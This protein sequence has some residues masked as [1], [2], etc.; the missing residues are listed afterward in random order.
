[1]RQ[2]S[3]P[4]HLN[5]L[6]VGSGGREHA[7]AWK[8]RQSKR[9]RKIYATHPENPGIAS[10]CEP[11]GFPYDPR[12]VYRL[13][14]F[15]ETHDVGLVV[16]GPELPL[17]EGLADKLAAPGRAVVGPGKEGAQLEASKSWCKRIMRSASVP[18]A[19]ARVFTDPED[20]KQF[21]ES[22]E[23]H[24][25][26]KASGLAAGKG[27]FV[28]DTLDE[29]LDAVDRIMVKKE[30][31]DA[32]REIVVEERMEGPEASILALVDGRSILVLETCQDHKR[33]KENDEG[34]NTGGMGAYSPATVVDA[35][36]MRRV[37]RE[38]LV[39][40]VD[41]L[42]REGIEYRG[43]LYAGMMLTPAG[44]KVLEFNVRFGDPE[45]Q[46]LM[47]RL[48]GDLAE[49][50]WRTATGTL[51]EADI[52]WDPRPSC[53]VVVAADGYPGASEK[54]HVIE[55]LDEVGAMPDVTVFHASSRRG[56]GGKIVTGG[57]RVLSVVA[58][59]STLAE[60]RSRANAAAERIRFKGRIYRRD[61]GARALAAT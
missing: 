41:V 25:V 3:L 1:M 7:L 49:V 29:A 54:G 2:P 16:I 14:R 44:P 15:C 34:P 4:E 51:A 11:V 55:G 8:L 57:G 61:I 37:E 17:A 60:A 40:M 52:D 45:C 35:G 13:P 26:V 48:K 38:V 56:E 58:L 53:C 9:V 30:F 5:V 6:L 47:P 31:G 19:D 27:V 28:P 10:L 21:L 24:Y 42:K 43:V 36:V 50:L 46:T 32:G 59:G 23:S 39:P 20:A 22:R 18:T 33:L 12:D